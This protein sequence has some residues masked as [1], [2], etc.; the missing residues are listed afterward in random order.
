M[1]GAEGGGALSRPSIFRGVIC[2]LSAGILVGAC[3]QSG[4]APQLDLMQ[5]TETATA[6]HERGDPRAELDKAIVYWGQQYAKSPRD[7]NAAVSYA[8]NLKA[9][10]QKEAALSVLQ[11]VSL[12]HGNDREIASEY[13]RLALEFGQVGLAQKL[14]AIA[15][16]PTKPDWRVISAQGTVLA[17]QGDYKGAIPYYENALR[18]APNQPSVMNNLAMALAADGQPHE[19]EPLLRRALEDGGASPKV[20]Q[21]LVVVLGLQGKY[22]EAEQAGLTERNAAANVDYLRRMVRHDDQ[23]SASVASAKARAPA[24]RPGSH[25]VDAASD[26]GWVTRVAE[27]APAAAL[28]PSQR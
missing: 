3:A 23:S 9:G 26:D 24:L 19:A 12:Y 2:A 1:S 16:D 11:Q 22:H 5:G 10:G 25:D 6:S 20:R 18:L 28:K 8:R 27:A 7:K 13:G 14:L 21:N 17:K 4:G 15:H